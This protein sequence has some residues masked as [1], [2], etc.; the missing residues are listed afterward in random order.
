MGEATDP[1]WACEVLNS[2]EAVGLRDALNDAFEHLDSYM[3]AV[4]FEVLP[5]NRWNVP[6]MSASAIAALG[7]SPPGPGK[8]AIDVHALARQIA[9]YDMELLPPPPPPVSDAD[10]QAAIDSILRGTE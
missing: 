9:D 3:M 6:Q 2:T 8:R 7:Q 1:Q 10:K 4:A 5:V